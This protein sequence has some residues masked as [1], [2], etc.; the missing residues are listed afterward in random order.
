MKEHGR[1][2]SNYINPRYMSINNIYELPHDKMIAHARNE[3]K[4]FEKTEDTE[5]AKESKKDKKTKKD[6]GDGKFKSKKSKRNHDSQGT[7]AEE[8][9]QKKPRKTKS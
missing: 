6:K 9:Q 1:Y 4:F 3:K 5:P 8:P 2:G 7:G